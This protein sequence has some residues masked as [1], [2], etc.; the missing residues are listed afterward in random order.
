MSVWRDCESTFQMSTQ[1]W[2]SEMKLYL[3]RKAKKK[4]ET[5]Y[6]ERESSEHENYIKTHHHKFW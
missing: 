4:Q 2:P 5:M 6:N 1:L 3:L